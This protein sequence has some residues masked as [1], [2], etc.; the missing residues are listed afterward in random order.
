MKHVN[1]SHSAPAQVVCRYPPEK[2]IFN[3]INE[4]NI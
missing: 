2:Y 1:L 4:N 3:L